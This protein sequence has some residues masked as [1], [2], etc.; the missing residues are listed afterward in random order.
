VKRPGGVTS[1]PMS[2]RPA[3]NSKFGRSKAR[4]FGARAWTPGLI[5]RRRISTLDGQAPTIEVMHAA[6]PICPPLR[7]RW[8]KIVGGLGPSQFMGIEMRETGWYRPGSLTKFGS[9]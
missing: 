6:F 1:P 2:F 3:H 7:G 9:P 4:A 8:H 5:S